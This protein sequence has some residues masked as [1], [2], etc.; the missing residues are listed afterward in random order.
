MSWL[1]FFRRSHKQ[2]E[3]DE[4]IESYLSIAIDENIAAG[5][6]PDEAALAARRKFG[7]TTLV[8][9]KVRD[10]NSLA[11]LEDFWSDLRHGARI[12]TFNPAFF[13]VATLSLAL[14]IGA[15]TAIFQL[16]NA[17][18]LRT[19]P[20]AH[21]EQLAKIK[22]AAN[23]HCCHGNI[24][25]RNSDLTNPIWEQVRDHQQGFSGVFAFG[26]ERFNIAERGE[27]RFVEGLWV[28]GGAFKTLGINPA[29]GRLIDESD[30]RPG[31]GSPV[32]VISYPFWRSEFGGAREVLGKKIALNGRPIEIVGVTSAGFY[33]VEVGR[34]VDVLVPI[35]SEPL[36]HG[37][38]AHLTRRRDWWLSVMGRIQPGWT[39]EQARAQLTAISKPVFEN[40]IPPNIRAQSA[41][42][43]SE[44]KLTAEPAASG[45]SSLRGQY[46]DPLW[47]LLAIAAA[48][49]LIACANLANLMLARSSV[50]EREMAV[51]LA[52]GAGKERLVRQL[53]TESALLSMAGTVLGAFLASW[54]SRYLVQFLSTGDA[55]LFLD[56]GTDWRM[57]AFTA[58]VAVVTC[59]LFGLTPALNAARTSPGSAMKAGGRSV[60]ADRSRFGLRRVLVVGQVAL[61]LVLLT[62]ALLFGRTLRNLNTVDTGL[63]QEGL[64]IAD[65]DLTNLKYSPERRSQFF[66]E[67]LDRLR[68]TPGIEHASTAGVVQLSGNSS[69]DAVEVLGAPPSNESSTW[70]DWASAGYFET[71][72]IPFLAGRDF[73]DR[74]TPGSPPVAVV[75]QSFAHKYLSDVDPI[76]RQFHRSQG[77][78]G[79]PDPIWRIV[80]VVRDS[81]YKSL[82]GDREPI[83]YLAVTQEAK[84][85][86]GVHVLLRSR[87]SMSALA[88]A[89]KRTILDAN[90]DI[91]I[92]FQ[93]FKTQVEEGLLRERLMAT[94]SGFFGLLAAILATV[95]LY[96]VISYM[97]ARRKN[98]IGIRVALGADRL[99]IV[100]LVLR[101]AALLLAIGLAIGTLITASGARI[102]KSL[103]YGLDAHDPLTIGLAVALL[104]SVSLGASLLPALRAS[105]LDPIQALREE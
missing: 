59:L 17:V 65:V 56:L 73:N 7:N 85:A 84:A 40:T 75:N 64:L 77:G 34:G 70:F 91:L 33:G 30:D 93:P 90:G 2:R 62:G 45:V 49:L 37:E 100:R 54:L 89:A 53:L 95:G 102:G 99:N 5:M 46:E 74:D 87:G 96:G 103:L 19:L 13:A 11:W 18:R 21:P 78:P 42:W 81:K 26:D 71:M 14:G 20:V 27:A 36:V 72:G 25:S 86:T 94:L 32:G 48:V 88:V 97:V 66:K 43:Y 41:Q 82:R 29:L 28:S 51:R 4:E 12:L 6:S 69:D 105:R 98:E 1:H 60:T 9:E 68:A 31:C 15:N 47:L 10:L 79:Q 67:L 52:I 61:S 104:G 76:G 80:G 39:L 23:E 38:A 63:R 44:Y 35:C 16:L 22:I 50:R 8:K 58:S 55:P 83:A 3:L 57:L 92:R 101:E 24:P